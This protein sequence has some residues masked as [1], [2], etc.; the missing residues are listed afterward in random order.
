MAVINV[1]GYTY[2]NGWL[3]KYYRARHPISKIYACEAECERI[4][5]RV[6]V[7]ADVVERLISQM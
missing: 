1:R 4:A 2:F 3:D 5:A 7:I 6:F